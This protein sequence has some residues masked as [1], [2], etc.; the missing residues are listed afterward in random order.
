MDWIT[1]GLLT[2][3][4]IIVALIVITLYQLLPLGD[5]RKKLIQQEEGS[6]SFAV[7]IGYLFIEI[8]IMTYT[9]PATP[10]IFEGLNPF[11]TLIV[12]SIIYLVSLLRAK[13]KYGG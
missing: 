3:L 4:I 8:G 10:E 6:Y 5:E 11:I 7:V 2:F 12:F 9:N 13:R 1:I